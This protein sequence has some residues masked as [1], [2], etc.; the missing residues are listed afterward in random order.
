MST[1]VPS[2][3][4]TQAPLLSSEE[5]ERLAKRKA[6]VERTRLWRANNPERAKLLVAQ[7]NARRK[8]A[9]PVRNKEKDRAAARA[10]RERNREAISAREAAWHKAHPEE[11]AASRKRYY[12]K[13]REVL[14]A[15]KRQ[16]RAEARA[17]KL[18]ANVPA[19]D[20]PAC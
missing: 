15:K 7:Q 13:N 2:K 16:K 20:P 11:T 4:E 19:Q 8:E 9:P 6:A 5:E 1:D 10:R 17:Q 18:A 14:L 3:V 12:E